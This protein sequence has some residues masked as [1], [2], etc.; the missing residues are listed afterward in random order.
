MKSASAPSDKRVV[1]GHA[2]GKGARGHPGG[3]GAKF[4]P[5]DTTGAQKTLAEQ[6]SGSADGSTDAVTVQASG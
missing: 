2:E 4:V 1:A 5:S 3:Q 6:V